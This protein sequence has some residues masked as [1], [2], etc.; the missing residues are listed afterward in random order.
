MFSMNEHDIA[1]KFKM[2]VKVLI[3]YIVSMFFSIALLTFFTH[4]AVKTIIDAIFGLPRILLDTI[5]IDKIVLWDGL[6][7]K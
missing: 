5:V 3:T 1:R 2:C 7:Y 4:T 6:G